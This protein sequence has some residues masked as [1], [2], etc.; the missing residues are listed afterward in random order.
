[1]LDDIKKHYELV[2]SA[3]ATD[4]RSNGARLITSPLL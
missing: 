4:M 1:M 2:P 3:S